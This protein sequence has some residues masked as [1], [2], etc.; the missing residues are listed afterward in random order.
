ME[1]RHSCT[2]LQIG[3]FQKKSRIWLHGYC[4]YP[5]Q[6]GVMHNIQHHRMFLE[7]TGSTALHGRRHTCTSNG[8]IL[9][10]SNTS[11]DFL[12]FCAVRRQSAFVFFLWLMCFSSGFLRYLLCINCLAINLCA[13]GS[14]HHS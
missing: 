7:C 10:L 3:C 6:C 1:I 2:V 13:F 4:V 9:Y 12:N 14:H 5:L 11:F 8:C